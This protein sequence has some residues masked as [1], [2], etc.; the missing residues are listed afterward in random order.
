MITVV[1]ITIATAIAIAITL[2]V[3]ASARK[4]LR[5]LIFVIAFTNRNNKFSQQTV[6]TNSL[7]SLNFPDRYF[8]HERVYIRIF[9]ETRQS[10][11]TRLLKSKEYMSCNCE[12]WKKVAFLVFST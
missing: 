4:F 6:S 12:K 9:T 8:I 1:V 10:F 11:E 5:P 7:A 3:T 2:V